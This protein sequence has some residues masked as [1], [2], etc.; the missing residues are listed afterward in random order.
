M[1]SSLLRECGAC[2]IS[3]ASVAT[4]VVLVSTLVLLQRQRQRLSWPG[5]VRAVRN[6]A[7]FIA[8]IVEFL[9]L[10]VLHQFASSH[11]RPQLPDDDPL[12]VD[13]LELFDSLDPV[14]TIDFM[15][16]EWTGTGYW[17]GHPL[18]GLLEAYHW[19]G[20]RFES[21]KAAFPLIFRLNGNDNSI[22][23]TLIQVGPGSWMTKYLLVPFT[24]YVRIPT[25]PRAVQL[26]HQVVLP[27]L[28]TPW[29]T[30]TLTRTRHRGRWT[31][32]MCY[33]DWPVQDF[34]RKYTTNA[35]DTVVL[36]LMELQGLPRPLFFLLRRQGTAQEKS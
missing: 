34:F 5:G 1:A 2:G 4:L 26:V 25:S 24:R 11:H 22:N 28:A 30:A 12:L 17:T 15:L 29:P 13:A 33:N 14:D 36:G 6:T 9:I 18:D 23:K 10:L 32:G 31:T 35:E 7:V 19:H 3:S 21:A 8:A 27:R 16:G 20:K